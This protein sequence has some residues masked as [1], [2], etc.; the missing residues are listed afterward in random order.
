MENELNE[1]RAVFYGVLSLL[2]IYKAASKKPED[3]IKLLGAIEESGFDDAACQSAKKLRL[4]LREENGFDEFD[5]EFSQLFLLPFDGNVPMSASV[6]HDDLEAGKPLLKV[7]EIL[8][9]AAL[10]KEQKNFSENEDNFG[11]LF[12]LMTKLARESAAGNNVAFIAMGDLYS[13]VIK[14]YAPLFAARIKADKRS[15]LLKEAAILLERFMNA[16]DKFY[17]S[18]KKQ[19]GFDD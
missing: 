7:K 10:R 3:P 15:R 14:P 2:F 9:I 6:Y 11:F 1:G 16:E 18:L 8:N 12:A 4:A 17:G 19:S 5:D 13:A